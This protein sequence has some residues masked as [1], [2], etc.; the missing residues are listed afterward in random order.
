MTNIRRHFREGDISFLTNVTYR[1]MPI[2]VDNS[3]LLWQSVGDIESELP[4]ELIAWVIMPDHFHV[5]ID[6][7]G[8][9]V[10]TL[11]QR[12]KLKFSAKYR[13]ANGLKSGRL[14]QYRFW[15]HIIRDQ[16]DLNRHI[17]Y[18]HYNPVK[19]GLVGSPLEYGQS[20]FQKYYNAGDYTEDWGIAED[21]TDGANLGE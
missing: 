4:F 12:I 20:S 2:L 18:I 5:V 21:P 19:H 13:S 15:D 11:M 17:D 8:T 10:P 16:D 1:R 14:W 7:K 9:D 6:P 3:D